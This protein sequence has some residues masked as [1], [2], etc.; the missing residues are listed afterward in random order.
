M[1]NRSSIRSSLIGKKFNTLIEIQDKNIYLSYIGL[2]L[3]VFIYLI[4]G[5]CYY[6]SEYKDV[7]DDYK[8]SEAPK[9]WFLSFYFVI[10]TMTTLGYGK[11]TIIVYYII[12][13]L[14]LL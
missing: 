13:I 6:I 14:L 11:I 3:C 7:D 8:G 4:V 10:T 1:D 12:I 9:T 5:M 2:V